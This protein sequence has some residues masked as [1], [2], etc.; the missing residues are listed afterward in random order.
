MQNT[1]KTRLNWPFAI[2]NGKP[3][4]LLPV[5]PYIVEEARW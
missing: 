3:L 2:V 1:P 4:P 5:K